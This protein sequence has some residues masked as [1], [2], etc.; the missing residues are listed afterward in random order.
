V[1]THWDEVLLADP[2]EHLLLWE[3]NAA[4]VALLDRM[5][6]EFDT[7]EHV[8]LWEDRRRQ[9]ALRRAAGVVG[10]VRT[11]RRRAAEVRPRADRTQSR[12][13]PPD[14]FDE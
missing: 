14:V 3:I 8:R 5:L 12:H 10:R 11:T 7:A 6:L 2:R 4:V 13:P 1:R 9:A